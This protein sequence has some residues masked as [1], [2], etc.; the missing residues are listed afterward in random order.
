MM[1]MTKVAMPI[2]ILVARVFLLRY[3]S[4][5]K[6]KRRYVRQQTLEK[7][8][9]RQRCDVPR[10]HFLTKE[11]AVSYPVAYPSKPRFVPTSTK[12]AFGIEPTDVPSEPNGHTDIIEPVS[13]TRDIRWWTSQPLT[14]STARF[15][16]VRSPFRRHL[17]VL[18]TRR[19]TCMPYE[20]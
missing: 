3:L 1:R 5:L 16:S 20:L 12:N 13:R 9:S 18:P 6:N 11:L 4:K 7:S 8:N 10:S 15:S 19:S 17:G 14:I 2:Y